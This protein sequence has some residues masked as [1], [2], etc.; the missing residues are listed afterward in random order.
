MESLPVLKTGTN[1]PYH[2]QFFIKTDNDMNIP[3]WASSAPADH[4]SRSTAPTYR[5]S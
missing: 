1:D 3:S 4:H 2:C 5:D